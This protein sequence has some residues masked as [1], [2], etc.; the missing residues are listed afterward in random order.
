[1]EWS[2]IIFHLKMDVLF[3]TTMNCYI[4]GFCWFDGS[5]TWNLDSPVLIT[6]NVDPASSPVQLFSLPFVSALAG[7]HL[8]KVLPWKKGK[9]Y[10]DINA[11]SLMP[12]RILVWNRII[13]TIQ[14]VG[15]PFTHRSFMYKW[16]TLCTFL[17]SSC[18]TLTIVLF[19][20]LSSFHLF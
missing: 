4:P 14:D 2:K 16:E 13:R 7:H 1:M 5:G 15:K 3:G 6:L 17:W 10:S 18:L 12:W 9:N 20:K 19:S 8:Q 11:F